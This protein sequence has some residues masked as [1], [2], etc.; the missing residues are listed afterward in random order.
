MKH[1]WK[2]GRG[3]ACFL[4]AVLLLSLLPVSACA[5]ARAPWFY[6]DAACSDIPEGAKYLDLL[7]PLSEEDEAWCAYEEDNG[8]RYQIP[9]ESEIVRYREEG[10]QSYTFHIR[11]ARSEMALDRVEKNY[12]MDYWTTGTHA[13]SEVYRVVYGEEA[14]WD[15]YA[16]APELKKARFAYLD[17]EGRI[18]SVTNE[19][20]I[21]PNKRVGLVRITYYAVELFLRGNELHSDFSYGTGPAWALFVQLTI[22]GILVILALGITIAVVYVRRRS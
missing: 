2:R 1:L 3:L 22:L 15:L 9:A 18:L 10:Y 13:P 4:L 17:E 14:A 21:Y 8:Q 12:W 5:W 7:L 6:A 16:H 11:G 20:S 19:S